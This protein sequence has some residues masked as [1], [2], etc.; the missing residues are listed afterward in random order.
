MEFSKY[1]ILEKTLWQIL[2]IK[3]K[4]GVFGKCFRGDFYNF[5]L[6]RPKFPFRVA[7]LELTFNSKNFWYFPEIS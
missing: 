3:Q 1:T 4:K 6:E 2:E 5:L 7:S